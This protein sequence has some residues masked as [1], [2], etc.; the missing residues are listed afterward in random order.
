MHYAPHQSMNAIVKGCSNSGRENIA[1]LECSG[2]VDVY[3]A[4][5]ISLQMSL[6]YSY[7]FSSLLFNRTNLRIIEQDGEAQ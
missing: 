4:T 7:L 5:N 2:V 1:I 3:I 6:T